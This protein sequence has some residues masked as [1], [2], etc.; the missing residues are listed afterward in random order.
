MIPDPIQKVP[1]PG[2]VGI[3]LCVLLY[4]NGAHGRHIQWKVLVNVQ[5]LI[6]ERLELPFDRFHRRSPIILK[7]VM[8][9]CIIC[10]VNKSSG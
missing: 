2:Q 7:L 9:Q 6:D 8:L 3:V 5:L 10:Q 1:K 4:Q